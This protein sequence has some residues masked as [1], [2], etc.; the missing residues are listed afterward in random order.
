MGGA[1]SKHVKFCLEHVKGR[2][3]LEDLV[4]MGG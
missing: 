3:Y 4:N 1:C 2:D